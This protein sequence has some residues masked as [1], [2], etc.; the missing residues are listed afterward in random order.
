M[1]DLSRVLVVGGAGFIGSHLVERLVERGSV[2]VFDDFSVGKRAFLEGA[3]ASGRCQIVEGNALD[4][5]ALCRAAAGHAAIFHLA[6]NPN[7][8]TRDPDDFEAVNHQ[9]KR[10]ALRAASSFWTRA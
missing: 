7:L 5:D 8:W 3:L 2:T 1:L 6:A 10:N 9:G 4:T